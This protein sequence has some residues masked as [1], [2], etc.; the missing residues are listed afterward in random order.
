MCA[1]HPPLGL[2]SRQPGR[3]RRHPAGPDRELRRRRLVRRY[4]RFNLTKLAATAQA[5]L[6]NLYGAIDDGINAGDESDRLL[7]SWQLDDPSLAARWRTALRSVLGGL[8]ASGARVVAFARPGCYVVAR[9]D[10]AAAGDTGGRAR[11]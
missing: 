5:Y 8:L 3:D 6:P 10:T 7:V 2:G 4:A 11:G 9:D 1:V